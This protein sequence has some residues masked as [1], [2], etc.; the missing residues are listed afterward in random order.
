MDDGANYGSE[1]LIPA[2]KQYAIPDK[3]ITIGFGS[4]NGHTTGDYW[5]FVQ[6]AMKG[7]LIQDSSGNEYFSASN[8]D[9]GIK[10]LLP[11]TTTVDLGASNNKFRAGYFSDLVE[12]GTAT[13]NANGSTLLPNGLRLTWG[14]FT[15]TGDQSKTVSFPV[16][17][18]SACYQVVVSQNTE[19]DGG[20]AKPYLNG[21][22]ARSFS[23]TGFTA[24]CW[25]VEES[26]SY[27]A[28][29]V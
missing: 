15:L 19:R 20:V 4:Y 2:G 11:K 9:I 28:I 23:T 16:E 12:I 29:G 7:L 24:E 13:K 5:R 26:Y 25:N 8:G 6:G 21:V 27:I 10:K 18:A 1:I 17:F 22:V 14:S 3:D